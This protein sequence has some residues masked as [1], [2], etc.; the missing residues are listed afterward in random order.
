M[1]LETKRLILRPLRMSDAKDIVENGNNLNISRWLLVVPYPY[2]LKDARSWIKHNQE[3]W[4]KKKKEDY[5]FGIEIKEERRIIGGGGLH[6]VNG[7]SAE[8]GYWIGEKYHNKGYGSEML[9]ALI[10]F[11]FKRLKLSR[12]EAGVF[13]G[14][15]SSGRLLEKYGFEKEGYKRQARVCKA[16]GKVKDEILYGLLKK[17]YRR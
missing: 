14:N 4:K 9:N 1:K 10:N 8:I 13:A 12:L 5:T 6:H 17:E 11:A 7:H 15:P 16:D 2:T 3:K